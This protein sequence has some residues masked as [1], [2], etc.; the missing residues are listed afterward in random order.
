MHSLAGRPSTAFSHRELSVSVTIFSSSS[1]SP[2]LLSFPLLFSACLLTLLVFIRFSFILFLLFFPPCLFSPSPLPSH[3]LSPCICSPIPSS[4][5][6][7]FPSFSL[8]PA[9]KLNCSLSR[10]MKCLHDSLKINKTS[11]H[12]NASQ[13]RK[14]YEAGV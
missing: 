5:L 6:Y 8:F 3:L 2:A 9:I 1:S 12:K 13:I 10:K 7:S 4:L 14:N 11:H